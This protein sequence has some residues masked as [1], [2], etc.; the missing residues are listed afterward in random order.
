MNKIEDILKA[1]GAVGAPNGAG[2]KVVQ[3]AQAMDEDAKNKG[4]LTKT[5]P[6]CDPDKKDPMTKTDDGDT[7]EGLK[8]TDEGVVA[9]AITE[10][11]VEVGNIHDWTTLFRTL[12]EV[13]QEQG[14]LIAT[15]TEKVDQVLQ[16]T[17]R[18]DNA[19]AKLSEGWGGGVSATLSDTVTDEQTV[20]IQRTAEAV[21]AAKKGSS[22]LKFSPSGAVL[23]P[24]TPV[25]AA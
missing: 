2:E 6:N 15:L 23:R 7:D 16:K 20:E 11:K 5:D 13:V 1:L 19:I 22:Q 12:T 21:A 17:E 24:R 10:L 25:A 14:Q 8:K 9:D 3:N 18:S 4:V